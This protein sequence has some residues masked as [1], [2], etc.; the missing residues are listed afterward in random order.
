MTDPWTKGPWKAWKSRSGGDRID[1]DGVS[2]IGGSRLI[3]CPGSGGAM[4]YS[5][6]VCQLHWAGTPEWD[7]NARLIAEAP[8]LVEAL[9]DLMAEQNGPPLIDPRHERAWQRA[10]DNAAAV[11]ARVRGDTQEQP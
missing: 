2:E 6:V 3:E 7:A 11:L 8:A 1:T 4:S 5:A 9:D 10:M